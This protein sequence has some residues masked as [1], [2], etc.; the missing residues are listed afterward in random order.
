M[1]KVRCFETSGVRTYAIALSD[2]LYVVVT[3][4]VYGSFNDAVSSVYL[5]SNGSIKI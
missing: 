1:R 3:S 2:R 4:R 5:K